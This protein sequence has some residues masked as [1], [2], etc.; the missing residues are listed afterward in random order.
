MAVMLMDG[1]DIAN[2][3]RYSFLPESVLGFGVFLLII[4]VGT[5]SYLFSWWDRLDYGE[6]STLALGCSLIR[7]QW[8]IFE[9][10]MLEDQFS[11][12]GKEKEE[13]RGR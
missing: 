10:R 9:K 8:I 5:K 11:D 7:K 6:F 1:I 13:S 12:D 2:Q 4:R 3:P